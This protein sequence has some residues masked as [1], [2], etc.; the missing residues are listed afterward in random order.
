MVTDPFTDIG[1]PLKMVKCD[2]VLSSHDHFDHNAVDG[3]D[4]KKAVTLNSDLS[5][6]KD[7]DLVAIDSFH[8]Q[9]LGKKRGKNRIYKFTVDGINFAHLGDLGEDFS[10]FLV[11]KIGKVDILFIPVGGVYTI[12]CKTASKFAKAVS[13]KI[14]VPM[15]YKTPRSTVGVGGYED[16]I[17]EFSTVKFL[18]K[19][20]NLDLLPQDTA[21]YVFDSKDF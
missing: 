19:E 8:D 18:P 4:Y 3:V 21:V 13:P 2:F 16:F 15:H 12:D 6:A 5:L 9:V 20:F 10:S 11:N 14:I 7:I 17:R 1:Y